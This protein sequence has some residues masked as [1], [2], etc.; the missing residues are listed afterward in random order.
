MNLSSIN[1]F[2]SSYHLSLQQAFRAVELCENEK[3]PELKSLA[4]F[5]LSSILMT[6][7]R[8]D[9][10]TFYLRESH[11]IAKSVLG[12]KHK[13]SLLTSKATGACLNPDAFHCRVRSSGYTSTNVSFSTN[14]SKFARYQLKIV[15]DDDDPKSRFNITTK[16]AAINK[17]GRVIVRNGLPHVKELK[18]SKRI[19]ASLLKSPKKEEMKNKKFGKLNKSLY[20][21]GKKIGIVLNR[22]HT[23]FKAIEGKME[24]FLYGCKEVMNEVFDEDEGDRLESVLKIQRWIRKVQGSTL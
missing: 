5:N 6:L 24:E 20:F 8:L 22:I 18:S 4:Y 3:F 23:I 7:N 19:D 21:Q 14:T 12:N 17:T 13:L 15:N 11:T 10:A 9:K 2:L 16:V 1:S